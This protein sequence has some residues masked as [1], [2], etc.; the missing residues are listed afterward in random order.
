MTDETPLKPGWWKKHK[1]AI[2]GC[3]GLTLI[4]FEF[5]NAEMRG[6][7]FHKEFLICGLLLCGVAIAGWG[8]KRS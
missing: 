7:S 8:D 4:A 6:A 3:F 5:V 1:E 2:L